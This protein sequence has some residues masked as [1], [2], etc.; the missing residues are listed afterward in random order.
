MALFVKACKEQRETGLI[1][2][3]LFSVVLFD[4]VYME[5][6]IHDLVLVFNFMLTKFIQL[7]IIIS[8]SRLIMMVNVSFQSSR[9][10]LS[11]WKIKSIVATETRIS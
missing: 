4:T 9:N 2:S 11:I 8:L 5:N 6:S 10:E 1:M 3:L 7:H